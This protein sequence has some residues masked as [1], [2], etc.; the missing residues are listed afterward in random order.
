MESNTYL[1]INDEMKKP[2]ELNE[3]HYPLLNEPEFNM[4]IAKKKEFQELYNKNKLSLEELSKID[5]NISSTTF[6]LNSQQLFVRNFLSKNTPYNN[7]LLYHG[8]G[9]GKTCSAIGVAMEKIKYMVETNTKK[10]IILVANPNVQDNFKQALFDEKKLLYN[11]STKEWRLLTCVGDDILRFINPT[12]E[13][14]DENKLKQ[15]IK[16]FI[17]DWFKFMGYTKFSN[18]INNSFK[19]D[20]TLVIIDEI[21]NIRVSDDGKNKRV[22]ESLV[23]LVQKSYDLQLLLLSATPMFDNYKEIIWLMNLMNMNDNR[24]IVSIGEIFDKNGNFKINN[25]GEEIGL[26][27]FITKVTGYISFVKGEDPINFP[28]RVFPT[29]YDKERSILNTKYPLYQYNN[30]PILVPLKHIDL[31]TIKLSDYQE[32]VYKFFMN[33]MTNESNNITVGYQIF[34]LPLNILNIS[35]PCEYF[36][37]ILM[38]K[39]VV[40]NQKQIVENTGKNALLQIFDNINQLPFTYNSDF[41][42]RYKNIFSL[43]EIKK[44]SSKI[45]SICT[46]IQKTEG[47]T[48]I[49]SEKIYSGVIPMALSLEEMGYSRQN[50]RNLLNNK[51]SNKLKYAMITGNNVYS[52]NNKNEIEAVVNNNNINGEKVKVIIISRAGSEGIDLKYI[53]NIHVLEPWYNM[54]R[55]EQVIGRGIRNKS[56]VLLPIE[57]RNCSIYLYGSILQQNEKECIDLYLYRMAEDKSIKI[58]KISRIMKE[59]SVDCLLTKKEDIEYFKSDIRE[60]PQI[61]SNNKE[62]QYNVKEKAFSASCDYMETCEYNCMLFEDNK[63]KKI[64]LTDDIDISTYNEKHMMMNVNDVITRIKDLFKEKYFYTKFDIITSVCYNKIY[65]IEVIN[66]ALESLLTNELLYVY[67]RYDRKGKLVHIGDL[68]LF[69]PG[70]I[71]NEYI[72]YH[73]R[74]R[75]IDHKNKKILIKSNENE[76]LKDVSTNIKDGDFLNKLIETIKLIRP[77]LDPSFFNSLNEIDGKEDIRRLKEEKK[78][79]HEEEKN[80]KREEKKRL[81]DEEKIRK[82]EERLELKIKKHKEILI[83]KDLAKKE[84]LRLREEKKKQTEAEKRT[85]KVGGSSISR[86]EIIK[87]SI[88]MIFDKMSASEKLYLI[89]QYYKNSNGDEYKNLVNNFDYTVEDLLTEFDQFIDGKIINNNFD[90]KIIVLGYTNK[91][92]II[93]KNEDKW[94]EGTDAYIKLFTAQIKTLGDEIS[95]IPVSNYMG[96]IVYDKNN[97]GIFKLKDNSNKDIHNKGSKCSQLHKS[98]LKDILYTLY[99]ENDIDLLFS[100]SNFK[101]SKLCD[102]IECTLRLYNMKQKEG[103]KWF[104]RS[105]ESSILKF[106]GLANV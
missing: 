36:D 70:E 5:E 78:R 28:Y 102:F 92:H 41:Y 76:K 82:R 85:K 39:D 14:L 29:D 90:M 98:N 93:V 88:E 95:I 80:R 87:L 13:E 66:Y 86:S 2:F 31:Y 74:I 12:N 104:Y 94:I 56:H 46:D 62:I 96:L 60:I 45:H 55:T 1:S 58:G 100:R 50:G 47:I 22:A 69:Q 18:E 64:Q 79:L 75:P 63:Y 15:K 68:F 103:K 48:L 23:S 73:E 16:L 54:N 42:K 17:G 6:T 4:K 57:K 65:S 59:V 24:P 44:Y 106:T 97:N 8:L 81:D 67:D 19:F 51:K 83:Q 25:D 34:Q 84:K 3:S 10:H 91:L 27:K 20:D 37:D 7:L 38:E 53:R 21:H 35:Y 11:K 26:K 72:N 32:K 49:Y 105:D 40:Y 89:N 61:L 52:P 33:N 71:K 9:T 101:I 77:L 99:D 30:D 43:Q